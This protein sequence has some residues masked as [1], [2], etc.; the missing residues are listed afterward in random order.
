MFF[1]LKIEYF[2]LSIKRICKLLLQ[3]KTFIGSRCEYMINNK[4]NKGE[5]EIFSGSRI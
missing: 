1:S 2:G 4:C 5:E 3:K